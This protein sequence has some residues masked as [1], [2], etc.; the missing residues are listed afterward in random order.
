MKETTEHDGKK[1]KWLAPT[2]STGRCEHGSGSHAGG[3]H[4]DSAV[5]NMITIEGIHEISYKYDT[6]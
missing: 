3:E 5:N 4:K 1:K 6:F 2:K